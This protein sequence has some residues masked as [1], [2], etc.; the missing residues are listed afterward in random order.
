MLRRDQ[1]YEGMYVII[2]PVKQSKA[3]LL[4]LLDPEDECT[5]LLYNV[6]T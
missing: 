6:G 5:T 1:H 4:G 2:M 3:S